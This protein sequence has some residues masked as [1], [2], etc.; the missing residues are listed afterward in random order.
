MLTTQLSL[1]RF[2]PFALVAS[3]P[4]F[5]DSI[6]LLSWI[7]SVF[8]ECTQFSQSAWEEKFLSSSVPE[9]DF[10][11]LFYLIKTLAMYRILDSIVFFLRTVKILFCFLL[12]L[13][14][15]SIDCNYMDYDSSNFFR[16]NLSI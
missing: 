13:S 16:V 3:L 5:L 1:L 15:W 10:I 4:Y 14:C 2:L 7:S 11:F 9:N 6:C 12:T 8:I